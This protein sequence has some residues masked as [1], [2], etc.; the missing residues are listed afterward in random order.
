M[1]ET[2]LLEWQQVYDHFKWCIQTT[3]LLM[4]SMG[5]F[6]IILEGLRIAKERFLERIGFKNWREAKIFVW[7]DIIIYSAVLVC[8]FSSDYVYNFLYRLG[9]LSEPRPTHIGLGQS[10]VGLVFGCLL[11]RKIKQKGYY[12]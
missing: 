8:N 11:W 12:K 7:E 6:F 4:L 3:F 9:Y 5:L 10:F 1:T 2:R